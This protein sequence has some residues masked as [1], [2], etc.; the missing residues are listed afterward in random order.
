[1]L[2]YQEILAQMRQYVSARVIQ[3][4]G[5]A[6]RNTVKKIAQVAGPLGWLDPGNPMP[7]PDEI[8]AH[9]VKEPPVPERE[10]TVEPY[11]EKIEE[12]L[13][14]GHKPLAIFRQLQREDK[15]FR[16][17]L[18][19]VK[20]FIKRLSVAEPEAYVVLHFEPGEAA[21]VDFGSGPL[22]PHPATGKPTKTHVFVMTLCHSRHQYAEL[23]WDQKVETWLR[24]HRNAFEFFG[25]VVGQVIIDNLKSAITRACVR[26]P[27]V[28]RSYEQFAR[29]YGFQIKP[30]KPRTPR[31]K[32]RVER[33]V[34][35]FKTSFMPLREFRSLGH[36]NQQL[37]EWVLGEA[38]NR[39]HGTTQEV[40]LRVFAEREK[41][42]L[43]ALPDP[44]PELRTW[45]KAKV[46][47]NCHL[48]F[49]KSYYSAPYRCIGVELEVRAGERI[50]ELYRDHEL[51]AMHPRAERP[52][53]W[54]TLEEH[55]P[56][57]KVAYLQKTPR[58]CLRRAED[59]GPSCLE[60]MQKLL[61]DRVLDR[62]A[63]AQGVLRLA[64]KYGGVRLEAAC[65]RALRFENISCPEHPAEG[66]RSGS[67]PARA[68]RPDALR[69][70]R[71]SA[72][73]AGHRCPAPRGGGQWLT[74]TSSSPNSKHC[75]C[76]AF[77]TRWT[78]VL[79]K[80]STRSSLTS[81]SW[82]W[83]FR[84]STN[85]ARTRSCARG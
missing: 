65:A 12:W 56:P 45:A 49:E 17:S 78:C 21:Q 66:A 81:S 85:G 1:M 20:R 16:G 35:Y 47:P 37:L 18:G 32:G 31:H 6:S 59:I 62:L 68:L 41:A 26:E 5:L 43:K 19:A 22:V 14:Q 52:G 36:G 72:F 57:S 48:N 58:W 83:C 74:L 84:T 8:V 4:K 50:V 38:G 61:G 44:R 25:G 77:W 54:L 40:P 75:G 63:G 15:P 82:V 13:K 24:C 10:S 55:Y 46:H 9:L 53:S 11:R 67:R 29:D 70:P 51:V 64:S 71:G 60:F 27:E 69:L 80:P 23:V 30:C 3:D 28:Q 34:G 33:G 39:V 73:P 7:S 2:D 79:S 76:R 42:A